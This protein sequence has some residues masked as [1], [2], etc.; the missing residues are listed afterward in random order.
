LLFNNNN[1][2]GHTNVVSS[3]LP[4]CSIPVRSNS[5]VWH[6]VDALSGQCIHFYKIAPSVW[7]QACNIYYQHCALRPVV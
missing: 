4:H 7:H 1:A 2:V 5:P 3:S 6:R